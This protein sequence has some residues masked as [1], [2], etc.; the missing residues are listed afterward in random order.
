MFDYCV[1]FLYAR[2]RDFV[3]FSRIEFFLFLFME[4]FVKRRCLFCIFEVDK[5]V[6]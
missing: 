6:V 2:I 1:F 3:N 5:S 4:F